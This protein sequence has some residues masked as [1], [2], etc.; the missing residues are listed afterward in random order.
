V[1]EDAAQA[2]GAEYKGRKAGSI[3]DYGCFS[4]FPSKNLGAGGDGGMIVM[5][6]EENYNL[7]RWLRVHGA[8]R[9][10]YHDMVGYNSRLATIQAAVLAVKLPH[11]RKWSK[12]RI[13]HAKIYDEALAGVNGVTTPVVKEYSTFHIYNQYTVA[14]DERDKVQAALSEAKIG[15]CV[16]YPVPFHKQ[17][18][19]AYLGHKPEE[20]PNASRASEQVLSIPIYPELTR[21]EQDEV[22]DTIRSAVG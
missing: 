21:A 13:E 20:F 19:F 8:K 4:F 2:I 9:K 15:N 1:V 11:L 14:F 10:Y 5:R 12:Q 3:G 17:P 6:S 16:Y 22:I 18:C 7:C